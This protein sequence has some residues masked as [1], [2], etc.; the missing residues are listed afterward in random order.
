M[1]L[2][3]TGEWKTQRFVAELPSRKRDKLTAIVL[4]GRKSDGSDVSVQRIAGCNGEGIWSMSLFL[5]L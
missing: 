3:Q 1:F 2:W 5:T 4:R